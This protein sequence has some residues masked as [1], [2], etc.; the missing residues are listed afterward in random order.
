[1]IQQIDIKVEA[2]KHSDAK[3]DQ[4]NFKSY[5]GKINKKAVKNQKSKK[6]QYTIL[7]CFAKQGKMLF[8][9]MMIIL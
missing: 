2:L 3:N 4:T 9:F 1:M 5:L 6:T 8:R 7:K